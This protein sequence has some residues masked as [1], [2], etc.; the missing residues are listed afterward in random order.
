VGT[1]GDDATPTPLTVLVREARDDELAGVGELTASAYLTGGA[2]ADAA[3]DGYLTHLRDARS[4]ATQAQLLVA[5]D[6]EDRV[7]GTVT[8]C[9]SGSPW[10]EIA[11]D[12]EA[13]M[14]MLAVP[15]SLWGRGIADALVDDVVRRLRAEGVGRLVLLV[16][17]GNAAPVRLYSR[18]GFHAVPERDRA[19]YEG[20]L[21]R[22]YARDLSGSPS[23]A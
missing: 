22:A 7:V 9:R 10:A 2:L 15:P 14:R 23:V 17:D 21:L 18:H 19:P 11:R 5:V 8:V 16:L 3:E 4:R 6:D 1:R 20:L 13:E 12:G